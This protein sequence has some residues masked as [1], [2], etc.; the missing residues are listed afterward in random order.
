MNIR[1]ILVRAPVIPVLTLGDLAHAV[2]LARAL[3]G[4]GLRVLEITLQTPA[5]I[6]CIEAIRT[7]LPD[8]TLAGASV[9]RGGNVARTRRDLSRRFVLPHRRHHA[10][11]R[12]R[13]LGTEQR[14]IG[15]RIL[16]GAARYAGRGRLARHRN[17]GSKRCSP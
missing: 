8:E 9:G 6:A 4:G 1:E 10:R 12:T 16:D 14:R 5:A 11:E 13:L 15:E 7:A 3:T 2:P 17:I